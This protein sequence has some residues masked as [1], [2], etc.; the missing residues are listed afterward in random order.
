[1]NFQPYA[2]AI[3]RI[4]TSFVFLL[5]GLQKIFG[6]YGGLPATLP[7]GML[8]VL[9]TAGWIETV[10]GIL[11]LLG[12]FTAPV[13]FILSGEMAVAFFLGHVARTGK[14]LT[15]QN[16]GAEPVLNCFIFLYLYA[17]GAGPWSI[18]AWRRRGAQT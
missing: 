17:A 5:H 9:R 1:M 6:V 18:D 3:L 12:L 2:Q 10:G 11:V 4:V 8:L 15:I 16:G 13:A 14:F 7:P